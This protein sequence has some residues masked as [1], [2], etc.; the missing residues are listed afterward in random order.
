MVSASPL[1]TISWLMNRR[2]LS[3]LQ[4]VQRSGRSFSLSPTILLH[5]LM[6]LMSSVKPHVNTFWKIRNVTEHE[7]VIPADPI[8]Q[9]TMIKRCLAIMNLAAFQDIEYTWFDRV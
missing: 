8:R 4:R 1:S 6:Q 5:I 9:A 2:G 7:D 3:G